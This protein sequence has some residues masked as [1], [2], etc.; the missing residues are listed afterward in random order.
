MHASTL[1]QKYKLIGTFKGVNYFD[2]QAAIMRNV[3]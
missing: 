2:P 1:V 3:W